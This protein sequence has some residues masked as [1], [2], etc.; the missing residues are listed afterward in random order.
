MIHNY[1]IIKGWLTRMLYRHSVDAGLLCLSIPRS[2]R[3]LR[4]H[5]SHRDLNRGG[6]YSIFIIVFI[7]WATPGK[8]YLNYKPITRPCSRTEKPTSEHLLTSGRPK[9]TLKGSY[10]IVTAPRV[11]H[12]L[13]NPLRSLLR[14]KGRL[15]K[16]EGFP[17][18][19]LPPSANRSLES[20]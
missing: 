8:S 20:I 17:I 14:R 10:R 6:Q 13:I 16:R 4:S 9:G 12:I 18:T 11:S 3:I 1:Y 5:P 19:K 2:D 15:G 7:L